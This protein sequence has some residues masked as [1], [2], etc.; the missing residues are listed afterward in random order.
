[1]PKSHKRASLSGLKPPPAAQQL[2]AHLLLL[3][4]AGRLSEEG[5]PGWGSGAGGRGAVCLFCPQAF[6]CHLAEV[7]RSSQRFS[8]K[9]SHSSK[10]VIWHEREQDSAV[11]P[12]D[13]SKVRHTGHFSSL[14]L[15][16][17]RHLPSS[18]PVESQV[19]KLPQRRCKQTT[20]GAR[21]NMPS[22]T[23]SQPTASPSFALAH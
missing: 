18:A 16:Q 12:K 1:M 22:A 19:P 9:K 5:S 7:D 11:T 20:R 4:L 14:L 8:N 3:S 10:P 13:A 17:R 21:R 15:V 23:T 6:A 2:V